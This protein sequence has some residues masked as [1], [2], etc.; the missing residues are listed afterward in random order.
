LRRFTERSEGTFNAGLDAKKAR[1]IDLRE[2]NNIDASA[3]NAVV[4]A[5]VAHNLA[6]ESGVVATFRRHA[7]AS[8]NR[9]NFA[10]SA[11]QAEHAC[12]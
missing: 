1:T 4:H 11:N 6:D 3:F 8:G 7:P 12:V 5:T 9:A 2:G 10:E